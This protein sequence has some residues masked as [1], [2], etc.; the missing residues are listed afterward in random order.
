MQR[1]KRWVLI[2][3]AVLSWGAALLI[4]IQTGLPERAAYT[5]LI[6][7]N[8]LPIAPEV[9]AFAPVI[10][11][12]TVNGK[13]VELLKLRGIPVIVNF[14]A[15]WCEPCA[16]EMPEL[17]QLFEN[18]GQDRIRILAVNLGESMDQVKGW[19][20]RLGL[21]FDLI[22]DPDLRLM[23][24]YQIRGQPTTFVISAEGII[25]H[26]FYGPTTASVLRPLVN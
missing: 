9:G 3:G 18:L 4:L 20:G 23:T 19:G 26:V 24:L 13:P 1:R 16:V 5:G 6:V 8:Q 14:W 25:T 15:T 21:S 11:A 22:M 10:D 2:W 12:V 7:P 17:Q